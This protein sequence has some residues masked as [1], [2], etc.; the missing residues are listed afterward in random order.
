MDHWF[1]C[2]VFFSFLFLQRLRHIIL[3]EDIFRIFNY[4]YNEDL[5]RRYILIVRLQVRRYNFWSTEASSHLGWK[6]SSMCRADKAISSITIYL[7]GFI[8]VLDVALN[9]RET[10]FFLKVYRLRLESVSEIVKGKI[11][12]YFLI[13]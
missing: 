10:I 9:N 12:I 7:Y 3:L 1:H 8:P 2:H 13:N 11:R 6:Y 4:F 5:Y